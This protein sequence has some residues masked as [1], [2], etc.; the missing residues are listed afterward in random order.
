MPPPP[1]SPRSG[2]SSGDRPRS[3]N[4]GA[5]GGN[6]GGRPDGARSGGGGYRGSDARGNDSR[7]GGQ[8]RDGARPD[9]GPRREYVR[10]PEL[11]EEATAALLDRPVREAVL[12]LGGPLAAAVAR[13]LA[14]V[15]L[16]LDEDPEAAL[17]HAQYA[18]DRAGR[19]PDVRE[20]LGVAAYTA[21]RYEL[22]R[23]ELRAAR[24]MTGHP[25]L[26]P[27]LADCERGLGHPERA[28]Q[29]A[30][31]PDAKRLG[32][33]ERTELA[34]VVAGARRDMGQFDAALQA[35]EVPA[36]RGGGA[37]AAALRVRYAYADTLALAGRR[38]EARR[39]F[40][41]L[42]AVDEGDETDAGERA[43]ELSD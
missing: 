35:L 2:N 27:L 29:V 31:E 10:E 19:L 14:A 13:H 26:L 42:A 9:S 3:D 39:W 24:R 36:L 30:A 23:A 4:G 34:I 12:G 37:S 7:G 33:A 17:A 21:G 22:A 1:R 5:A 43:D 40:Q 32:P 6:R 25:D 16:L 38:A 41:D 28:L 18:K 8:R 15:A 11:P 20:A